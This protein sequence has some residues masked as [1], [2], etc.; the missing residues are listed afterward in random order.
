MIRAAFARA[1]RPEP[2]DTAPPHARTM[3][4]FVRLLGAVHLVAF[5]SLVPQLRTL[6]G[7]SGLLPA[8]ESLRQIAS[9]AG[10]RALLF[11]DLPT[12]FWVS[13]SDR[14][15]LGA[16]WT[17]VALASAVIAGLRTRACL[18]VLWVLYLSFVGAGRSFFAWQWDALLC[19]TTA[20]ALFLPDGGGAPTPLAVVLLRFLVFRFYLGAGIAKLVAGDPAWTEGVAMKLFFETA[21]LPTPLGW[22]AAHLPGWAHEALGLFV[23]ACEIAVP[24]LLLWGRRARL[25]A[26]FALSTLQLGIVLTA[27]FG[28]FNWLALALHVVLLDDRFLPGSRPATVPPEPPRWR[29]M[30]ALGF[31]SLLVV[32]AV[33]ENAVDFSGR[34]ALGSSLRAVRRLWA[35]WHLAHAYHLFGTLE[36]QRLVVE[37]LGS[38]DGR[39][40]RRYELRHAT[41]HPQ[42]APSWLGPYLPRIAFQWAF[43]TTRPPGGARDE[44][45]AWFG[46]LLERIGRRPRSV[47]RL[48]VSMPFPTTAP[49]AVETRIVRYEIASR[50]EHARSGA[51]WTRSPLPGVGAVWLP[52]SGKA[53]RF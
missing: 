11:L 34:R 4:L 40:F 38:A 6:L 19:E 33:V 29:R 41:H 44:Q 8:G 17:G 15:L 12:V 30:T 3:R 50:R 22:W 53:P 39:A 27:S 32:G 24:F 36:R 14:V 42:R 49:R 46:R 9:D 26:F 1:L 20:I 10:S 31:A 52:G 51:F 2:A 7:P 23:L 37:I 18:A 28:F 16:A 5:A 21:P 43:L 47:A 13:A 25:A 35:P 45:R 48:F